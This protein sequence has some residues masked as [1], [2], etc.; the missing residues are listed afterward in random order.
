[1]KARR[2]VSVV[3]LALGV[4]LPAVSCGS[5]GSDNA[6]DE[7]CLTGHCVPDGGDASDGGKTDVDPATRGVFVKDGLLVV[8]GVKTTLFGGEL[9]YFRIRDPGFDAAK[10][11]ALWAD[12][13]AKMKAAG[14]NLVTTYLPWDYHESAAGQ[15]DF[16]GARDVDRFF[17]IACDAGMKI[18]A[19]PGPLITSEWPRGFGTYGAVPEWWK[20]AHPGSL[21]K[22]SDGSEFTFSPTGDSTQAQ[23]SYL[24]PAYLA[25]V[26]TWFDKALPIIA[27]YIDRRCIVGVQVDNE[28][29]LYWS[30]R[31]GSVDYSPKALEHWRAFLSTRYGTIG[32]LNTA[33]GTSYASFAAVV[34]PAKSPGAVAENVAGRDWYDAGQA[35]ILDYLKTIRSMLEARGIKEPDVLFFTNDSPFGIPLRTVMVHDG[36]IKNQVGVAALDLYPKQFPTNGEIDDNPF[37]A[38]YFTKLFAG[39]NRL[40]TK[41][42][43]SFSFAAELQGGFYDFP[44]GVKPTVTPEATDHLLAKTFGHGLRGGA[45]YTIRGGLNLDGS[46]Y[47]FQAAIGLDG[48]LR[49]RY[50]VLEAWGNLLATTSIARA[51][52]VEDPIA[53]VQDAAYAVPQAG[54][55]DDMQSLYTSEY[56]GVFGW[57]ATAGFNPAVVDAQNVADLARYKVVFF[58]APEL[59]DPATARKL[60]AFHK[61]GGVLVQMLDTGSRT[62]LGKSDPDVQALA[63]LFPVDAAGSYSWPGVP[64]RSGTANQKLTGAEGEVRTYWYETFW[65]PKAGAAVSPLVFERTQP[66][67]NDGK[68]VA[69]ETVA[70]GAPR[71]FLGGHFASIFNHS[72]YFAADAAE[73]GRKRALAR[74][75][76]QL[77]GVTPQVTTSSVRES[78]WAVKSRDTKSVF[79]FVVLDHDAATV[80]VELPGAAALGLVDGATYTVK[81]LR[82]GTDLGA[83]T[84]ATLR[85]S[86]VDV[87]LPRFGVAVLEIATK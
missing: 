37:Q 21:V 44:L 59:V 61:G 4:V 10:T 17:Q 34:P 2:L 29:N 69:F 71:A 33:H 12:S 14:M 45:L 72:D 36:R 82:R 60:T 22:K 65:T 31:F 86:G 74:H 53:I 77:G 19:K 47:D 56:N 46:S 75:L 9:H 32:A 62:L 5:D 80:H 81:D 79:V 38:D 73:L 8:D 26:G 25:S 78:A 18:V 7:S 6:T 30:D 40:Y 87:P 58:L 50:D 51:D 16:T 20:K 64:L 27:K 24:D 48:S 68:L 66:F 57:L 41:D 39:Y 84:G 28:T 15:W 35:Y 52:E 42:A 70:G 49:P 55:K 63:A 83:R 13:V 43:G 23:P 76:V 11:Q 3:G 1:M 85:S 67:G 54:T